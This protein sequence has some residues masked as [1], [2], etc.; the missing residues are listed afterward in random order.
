MARC[1]LFLI[2]AVP[3]LAQSNADFFEAKI[4]PVLAKNCY[5]CHSSKLKSPMSGLALDTRSGLRKGG[6]SGPVVIPGKPAES[7]VAEGSPVYRP[8]PEHAAFGQA[9]RF[10][11]CGF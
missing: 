11:D 6:A 2:L 9:S 3:A 1:W 8:E 7:R 5:G 4:R 10:A